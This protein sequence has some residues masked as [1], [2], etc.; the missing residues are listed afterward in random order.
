MTDSVDATPET[1][2]VQEKR[3]EV[4]T[5]K[6][7][8]LSVYI[9]GDLDNLE[10][11]AV[12]LTVHDI[13]SNHSAFHEFVNLPCMTEIKQRSVFVHVD[14]PGQEDH[15]P[16]LPNDFVF[17]TIQVL[18]EDLVCVLDQLKIKL[19]VG[20]G[21]GAGANVLVRF[22]LAHP[23]RVLGLVLIH[24]VATGV[25]MMEYVK[26]KIM[27]WKLQN[28]GMH[29]S[30]EQYLVL[31][32][33]GA[34]L[35]LVDNKEKLIQD[36]T[37]KLKKRINPRNLRRYVEA[38]MN[39]KDIM[40]LIEAHLREMDVLLVSGSKAAHAQS[41][42][43]MYG[44]M[45]KKKTSML[46]VDSVGDVLAEAPDKLAQSLLLFV[47][48]LGFLTSVT[49]PGVERQKTH[50]PVHPKSLGAVG[51]RRTLSMEDYDMPRLRRTSLTANQK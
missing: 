29:P 47:K 44:R 48:G 42:Q 23:S 9:Q 21:E 4:V 25:G 17:P 8:K 13:G 38:Y 24:C 31:H 27:N 49:L 30:A 37:E 18:G 51:R 19:V 46:K 50:P 7:G 15:A 1:E 22:A 33:F 36:Y 28:Q 34:Q 20:F 41:V 32:K 11:K 2:I 10:K 16:D 6:Y 26:D 5:Q 43:F 39:R 14:I 12:F 40:G 35:E 3:M 45:D